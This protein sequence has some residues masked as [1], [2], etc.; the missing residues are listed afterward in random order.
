MK[1][2]PLIFLALAAISAAL[3]NFWPRED[4]QHPQQAE[5]K[6]ISS[7]EITHASTPPSAAAQIAGLSSPF[8]RGAPPAPKSLDERIKTRRSRMEKYLYST[9]PNYFTMTLAELDTRAKNNDVFALLQLAEQ[10]WSEG[11]ELA[12]DPSYDNKL[13]AKQT[14][15]SY[16]IGA[17]GQGH[18]RAATVASWMY[19]DQ[20][21]V[22]EAYAWGLVSQK[23]LDRRNDDKVEAYSK[24]LSR[25]QQDQAEAIA[26]K[27]FAQIQQRLIAKMGK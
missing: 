16:M 19:E 14:A 27:E 15:I 24:S 9:P 12:D 23:M 22:I 10:Y 26:I 4:S 8:G 1:K 21:Q 7:T 25:S 3:Y 2:T 11:E 5:R 20:G 13:P 17:A 6:T 18:S